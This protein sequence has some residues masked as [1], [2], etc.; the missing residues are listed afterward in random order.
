MK[1][2]EILITPLVP[3]NKGKIWK[4]QSYIVFLNFSPRKGRCPKMFWD[5]GV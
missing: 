2:K 4:I 3:L 1:I 5:R